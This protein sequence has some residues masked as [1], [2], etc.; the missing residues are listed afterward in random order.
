MK[1]PESR[2]LYPVM[3]EDLVRID[4]SFLDP[5]YPNVRLRMGLRPDEHPGIDINLQGTYGN[6]DEGYPVVA[7]AD[8]IVVH[9]GFHRVWGNI[10]LVEHPGLARELGYD[11]LASQYAHLK[12]RSV[13]EGDYIV[14]GEPVGSIGRGDPAR[15]FLAHLHFEIRRAKLPADFW[16]GKDV[17][18][19]KAKYL[20]PEKF[21]MEN[22][23]PVRRTLKKVIL[24]SQTK[25]IETN[26]TWDRAIVNYDYPSKV[27]VKQIK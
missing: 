21:L 13:K 1:T 12:F 26:E 2:V 19:I 22:F 6:K 7:M 11:Y 25:G 14:A 10:V 23:Q 4:T 18:L 24:I 3:P 15:P 17:E 5:N 8:G 20:D 27:Y 9:S 16:P